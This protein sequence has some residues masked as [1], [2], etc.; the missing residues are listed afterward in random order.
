MT[1][2]ALIALACAAGLSTAAVADSDIA[3]SGNDGYTRS[4]TVR[5]AD[6]NLTQASGKAALRTRLKKAVDAVCATDAACNYT[7]ERDT[8]R[9]ASNAIA[10]AN[11]QLAMATPT[12][13]TVSGA[14]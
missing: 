8:A 11:G 5:I 13:L 3:V 12:H 7:A 9:L 14:R 4:A 6:L 1:K 2:Y 10:S